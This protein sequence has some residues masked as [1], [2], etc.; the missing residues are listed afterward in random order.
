[1]SGN[2]RGGQAKLV[3]KKKN[4][5]FPP[6]KIEKESE[7]EAQTPPPNHA[8]QLK[9]GLRIKAAQEI[10]VFEVRQ[11]SSGA[12]MALHP[13][14]PGDPIAQ[15]L[16]T[17]LGR[18]ADERWATYLADYQPSFGTKFTSKLRL[19][20]FDVH[21]NGFQVVTVAFTHANRQ[22]TADNY[23]FGLSILPGKNNAG[24]QLGLGGGAAPSSRTSKA[25]K[26]PK[27]ARKSKPARAAKKAKGPK[28]RKR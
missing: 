8:L 15:D 23:I 6:A 9:L 4:V 1:M 3:I 17:A 21:D 24:I 19:S 10:E 7:V 18:A 27:A 13:Q 16:E 5:N 26:Q 2:I 12:V 14:P 20:P 28:R 11:T 25:V 22:F